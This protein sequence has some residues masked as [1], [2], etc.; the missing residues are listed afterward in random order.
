MTSLF[1]WN[2]SF[3]T[4]LSSVD[5]QHQRL[6]GLVNELAELVIA[7]DDIN[8]QTYAALREEVLDYASVHFEDEEDLMTRTGLDER[9]LDFISTSIAPSSRRP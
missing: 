2:D 3:L 4:H 5:A 7:A 6:V 9:H 8:P 1:T